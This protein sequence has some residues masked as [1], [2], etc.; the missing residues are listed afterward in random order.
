MKKCKHE[1]YTDSKSF[2]IKY[3]S[4]A[5]LECSAHS[6][7][8]WAVSRQC[9][10]CRDRRILAAGLEVITGPWVVIAAPEQRL[11]FNVVPT[12]V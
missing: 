10:G 3:S 12:Y 7:K 5:S 1:H 9:L 2:Y 11:S 8:G 4:C 6:H